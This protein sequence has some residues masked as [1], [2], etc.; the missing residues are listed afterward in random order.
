MLIALCIY[1]LIDKQF[2][3]IALHK[4]FDESQIVLPA[5]VIF[6]NFDFR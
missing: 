2:K 4:R 3:S 6:R 1:N 5:E